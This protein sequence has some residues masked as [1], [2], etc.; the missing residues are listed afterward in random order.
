MPD[1]NNFQRIGVPHNA[2]VGSSFEQT[3][4]RFFFTSEGTQLTPAFPVDVG[5]STLKK[6]HRFDLGSSDPPILVECKSHTWTAGGYMPAAKLT[7]WNEAM[8]YFH[9]APNEYRKVMF[10]LKHCRREQSLATYYLRT[11]GHLVPDGVEFWEFDE[12]TGI[13][14]RLR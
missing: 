4:K 2:G 3:A 10:V 12:E 5:V 14:E 9:I 7:V 11:Y 8:Y 13:A 1:S 6:R